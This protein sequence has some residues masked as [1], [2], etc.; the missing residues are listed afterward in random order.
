MKSCLQ[1][2]KKTV[3][4]EQYE[5]GLSEMKS[6]NEVIEQSRVTVFDETL[7]NSIENTI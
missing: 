5:I 7:Q 4:C 6:L 3:Q 1:C 2:D